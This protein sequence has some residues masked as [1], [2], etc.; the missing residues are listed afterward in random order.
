MTIP[1]SV[2][3]PDAMPPGCRFASRCPFASAPCD[4]GRPERREIAA[5][6]GVACIK[7]PLELHYARGA[8]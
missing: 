7:A 5:R 4:A 2:P 8:A 1:G 3:V 6:H